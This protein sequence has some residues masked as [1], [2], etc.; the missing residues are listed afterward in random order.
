MKKDFVELKLQFLK[1][2]VEIKDSRD[3]DFPDGK[4]QSYSRLVKKLVDKV[5]LEIVLSNKNPHLR[6][7]KCK[8]RVPLFYPYGYVYKQTTCDEGESIIICLDCI[9]KTDNKQLAQYIMAYGQ[10]DFPVTCDDCRDKN[11]P[12]SCPIKN[13]WSKVGD[14]VV[15]EIDSYLNQR[16]RKRKK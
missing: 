6:C 14:E 3:A 13:K 11:E 16:E 9:T 10:V 4:Y 12:A 8:K 1:G 5:Y 7:H 15:K 2:H